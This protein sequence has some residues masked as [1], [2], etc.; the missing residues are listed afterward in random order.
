MSPAAI[1]LEDHCRADCSNLLAAIIYHFSLA[2][3]ADSCELEI[4]RVKKGPGRLLIRGSEYV[5]LEDGFG[6]SGVG[7]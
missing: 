1:S 3:K 4:D 7:F 6:T 2:P 5:A